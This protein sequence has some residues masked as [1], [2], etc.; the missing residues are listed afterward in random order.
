MSEFLFYFIKCAQNKF[1]KERLRR[2]SGDNTVIHLPYYG[3][4]QS[5][6]F[7]LLCHAMSCCPSSDNGVQSVNLR[8]LLLEVKHPQNLYHIHKD[9]DRFIDRHF[10]NTV[11]SYSA[12]SKNI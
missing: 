6:S 11:K 10:L 7:T 5:Y 1:C 2:R 9:L 4:Q 12:P 8:A 3:R